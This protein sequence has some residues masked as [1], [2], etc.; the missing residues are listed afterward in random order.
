MQCAQ[1]T[2]YRGPDQAGPMF[3]QYRDSYKDQEDEVESRE[4][5]CRQIDILSRGLANVVTA[6][7]RISCT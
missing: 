7:E 2:L 3:N 1:P 5:G 6:I 4:Q